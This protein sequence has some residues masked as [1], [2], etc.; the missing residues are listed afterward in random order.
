MGTQWVA[1]DKRLLIE[2]LRV[3]LVLLFLFHDKAA[4]SKDGTAF[5]TW[6]VV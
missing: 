2:E 6:E 4:L 1:I 3:I 5:P